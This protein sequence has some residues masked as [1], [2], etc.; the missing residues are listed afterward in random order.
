VRPNGLS[1]ET[2]VVRC[3]PVIDTRFDAVINAAWEG[4]PAIDASLLLSPEGEWSHRYRLALFVRTKVPVRVPSILFAVGPFGDIKNYDDHHFYL[5]WYPAGLVVEG[6]GVDP[7]TLPSI[8]QAAAEE[9]KA[10]LAHGL[11][12]NMPV[13]RVILAAA[14]EIRLEGGWVFAIGRGSLADRGATIHR[15][16]RYGIRRK[17]RYFSVDTGKYSAAPALARRLADEVAAVVGA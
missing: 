15:R 14:E 2:L 5:S 12:E 16:D 3:Q 4:G 8:N 11:R 13:A 9:I 6:Q 1:D 7:P 10:K 17:D